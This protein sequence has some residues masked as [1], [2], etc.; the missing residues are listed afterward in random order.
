MWDSTVFWIKLLCLLSTTAGVISSI[1][2]NRVPGLCPGLEPPTQERHKAVRVDS[3]LLQK[4][5]KD[6]QRVGA[7]LL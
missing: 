2:G 4:D 5:D 6:N 3:Q 7:P 1:N